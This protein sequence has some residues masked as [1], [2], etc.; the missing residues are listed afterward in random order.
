MN[1]LRTSAPGA[2]LAAL[3]TCGWLPV[4]VL[5]QEVFR[6]VDEHGV[7]TFSD[8]ATDDA[9]RLQLPAAVVSEDARAEQ[10][11]LIDQQ[12]AVAKALEES[13]LAREAART[14]R[15][16]AL[17][18]VEPRTVYYREADRARDAGSGSVTWQGSYWRNG[19]WPGHR[20][21]HHPSWPGYPAKPVQPIEPPPEPPTP[22]SRRVPLPPLKVD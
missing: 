22:P 4:T 8:V 20:P 7:V 18:A 5:G 17:A 3:L 9:V 11:A 1:L 12:L 2:I 14:E 10:Q 15:L 6:S 21:G 13:R 16:E 19:Y